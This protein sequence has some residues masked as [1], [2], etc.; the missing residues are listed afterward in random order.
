MAERRDF[1]GLEWV[2]AELDLTLASA[3]EALEAFVADRED[4]GRLRFC[5]T[6]L[7]QAYGTLRMLEF[8][9]AEQLALELD[10][11]AQALLAGRIPQTDD[12]LEALMAGLVQLPAYIQFARAEG[13]DEPSTLVPL[14]Q[15]LRALRGAQVSLE[16]AAFRPDMAG[17]SA[18]QG[19]RV[20]PDADFDA[21]LR[22]LRQIFQVALAAV[23]REQE[24]QQN[25][26]RLGKVMALVLQMVSGHPRETLWRA[27]QGLVEGLQHGSILLAPAVKS[28]LRQLDRE[29]KGM[30]EQGAA[31]LD[32][33]P[34]EEPLQP[35][36]YYI[37]LS[38]AET[39][40]IRELREQFALDRA[41]PPVAEDAPRP[42]LGATAAVAAA[43]CE[44][45]GQIQEVIDVHVRTRPGEIDDLRELLPAVARVAST[46]SMLGLPEPLEVVRAQ[47]DALEQL[48]QSG[49]PGDASSVPRLMEIAARLIGVESA[50]RVAGHDRQ[51][52]RSTEG[53]RQ[54]REARQAV[55]RQCRT[56]LEQAKECIVDFVASQWQ[57]SRLEPL[58]EL[59][60]V[61]RGALEMLP[62]PECAE[63]LIGCERYVR[64]QLLEGGVQPDW[65]ALDL[66]ADA[67]GGVD[68]FIERTEEG[69]SGRASQQMLALARESVAQLG[70]LE[71][72][73]PARA[74]V[75]GETV[76]LPEA[77]VAAAEAEPQEAVAEV[78]EGDGELVDDEILEV[79]DEEVQEVQE[80]IDAALPAWQADPGDAENLSTLRR[81]FHTLKG[82]G[83]LVGAVALGELSWSIENMLN[84][85]I[86]RSVAATAARI[87]MA[88]LARLAIPGLMD[89]FRAG[90]RG[91]PD[92]VQALIDRAQQLAS[93]AADALAPLAGG[94]QVPVQPE[95]QE[96]RDAQLMAIFAAEAVSYLQ[97]LD[98]YVAAAAF[99]ARPE[100][101]DSL[102][103]ALHTLKGS[104][105]MA[106]VTR[107]AEVVTPIERL[108]KEL[109]ANHLS[110]DAEV[111]S[112]LG[113]ASRLV[114]LGLAQLEEAE[115]PAIPGAVDFV[116]RVARAQSERLEMLAEHEPRESVQATQVRHLAD[117]LDAVFRAVPLLLQWREQ[118]P[119]GEACEELR[120]EFA[121]LQGELLQIRDH[122]GS[123][124]LAP[125]GVLSGALAAVYARLDER[126]LLPESGLQVLVDAHNT[127]SDLLDQMAA[128]QTLGP[129]GEHL[130]ALAALEPFPPTL[131][132]YPEDAGLAPVQAELPPEPELEIPAAASTELD[133]EL[134]AEAEAAASAQALERWAS[135]ALHPSGEHAP[136]EELELAPP[137]G[138]ALGDYPEDAGLALALA[139]LP[140]EPELEI[141]AASAQA[142]E[143]WAS[144]A[145]HPSGE[146]APLEELELAPP[147]GGALGDYPE[148]AGLA[149]ALAE[150]P[151]E[152][153]LE[154]PAAASTELD[155]ELELEAEALPVATAASELSL[156]ELPAE[157]VDP[158]TLEIFLEEARELLDAM[159]P[160]LHAW[161]RD[162]ALAGAGD[163]L[164]RLLHTF[165]GG[166]RLTG[167]LRLGDLAHDCESLLEHRG[168]ADAGFFPALQ[169][170]FD[171]LQQSV[172]AL[173]A[174]Q[175]MPVFAP[176]PAA[177][178]EAMAGAVELPAA[179]PEVELVEP[180][181]PPPAELP[182]EEV[183][184][185]TL[186][187]FL[188]EAREL[189]DAMEPL[190]HAWPRDPAL[191]GAGDELKRLLHTFKGGARLTGLLRLGDLAHDCESLLEHR[192]PG[193]AGFFPALQGY[194]DRL[195]QSVEAL[196]A[197]GPMPLPAAAGIEAEPA[198]LAEAAGFEAPL[199][200]IAELTAT[201]P[202]EAPA[203]SAAPEIEAPEDVQPLP[204]AVFEAEAPEPEAAEPEAPA[205]LP[206]I[207]FDLA[208]L[209]AAPVAIGEGL[210]EIE[211]D[212]EAFEGSAEA[213]AAPTPLPEFDLEDLEE[214]L[215]FSPRLSD[216]EAVE[217][218]PAEEALPGLTPEAGEP[219]P[220]L[221]ELEPEWLQEELPQPEAAAPA[222]PLLALPDIEDQIDPDTLEI[223]LEE[224]WE[225]LEGIGEELHAWR[226]E[227]EARSHPE[228][229]KRLLHT[230]KGGAR[231]AGLLRLGGLAHEVETLLEGSRAPGEAVLA[232]VAHCHE[233][234]T[235]GIEAVANPPQPAAPAEA[236]ALPPAAPA[237][238]P[239]PLPEFEPV[240][241]P[242]PEPVPAG[243]IIRFP[244]FNLR[245]D[246]AVLPSIPLPL[247]EMARALDK[248]GSQEAVK[249]SAQL[250]EEL[251]NLAGETSISRARVE[252]QVNEFRHSL[253]DMDTTIHR[254]QDKLRRLD[255][256]TEAQVLFR[257]E[258]LEQQGAESWDPLEF[259]R[260]TAL[261]QLSRS[262]MESASDIS[263]LRD[264][265]ADKSRDLETLL[266]QQARINTDLQEGLM[267]S[268]MVPFSRMV[269]RLRRIVRQVAAELGKEVE[270]DVLNAEG[271]M[272]R[273]VME[274]MVAPLEHMLR[275]AVDHGIELP[276]DRA[277]ANKP[278][279][280]RIYLNLQ[281]EGGDIVLTLLDDGRGIDRE[282]VRR[283][284][285]E[286]GMLE[287]DARLTDHEILQF[288][289]QPGFSTAAA[290]TQI[291]GRGVGMDVV[292][293][294]IKLLGGSLDVQSELGS[295]SRFI[296]RLP[297]TVSVNRALMVNVGQDT[298]AVP[299]NTIEGI[300]RV[301][302]F[303][304]EAY[305]QPDAPLFEYAGQSYRM[306]YL[307]ALMHTADKP[308][309]SQQLMPLPVLLVRG[310][311]QAVAVQVDRLLGSRE[312]VVKPLGPQFSQVTGLSG[313]TVLGDG[314][315]VVILDLAAMVRS[316]IS[317]KH[318]DL[319]L[320]REAEGGERERNLLVM[321]VDDSVTVRKVTSRFL[322]RQGMDVL[323]AKDGVD[324]MALLQEHLP[325]LM[326]LDIEMPRMDGFEVANRMRH[327]ERLQHIPIIMITSRSGEKHRQRAL[328]IGVNKYMGKP[329]QESELLQAIES[330]TQGGRAR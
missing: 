244:E 169:G 3:R 220:G 115:P 95:V 311:E 144:E 223:F 255:M 308:D 53:E 101:S 52:A 165:K 212:A 214:L 164:K 263:D 272:D 200:E 248:R 267:R 62:L 26:D 327:S 87:E 207:E 180:V 163:E 46:L 199:T 282:A 59:L 201:A 278:A 67:I 294:E 291:S 84:R 236:E 116:A 60:H 113:E 301:S 70:G 63:I 275:N 246:V 50:L 285:V 195:Q 167:L 252:E 304:L 328:S 284:A 241:E 258:K 69:I 277:R 326:L 300:V 55:L 42:D 17:A 279:T 109:R 152:P 114:K 261:Q 139:E 24:T 29:F 86:D 316:D 31:W 49:A 325:D 307:G 15:D 193:D 39:P 37:A 138:G 226:R 137:A 25:L 108:V 235:S 32:A 266:V 196:E 1:V 206:E 249:I 155:I 18:R 34:G 151:P 273:S 125:L 211:F 312:V 222:L 100:L 51:A 173:E 61:V 132:D 176:P 228:E 119:A 142:L 268:R 4:L 264:T 197:G 102:Q 58:P 89:D 242:E 262:L 133:I 313:A 292:H 28:L 303:E 158:D 7:H 12:V 324:A 240:P 243:S 157:E 186:E 97:V 121:R 13:R 118:S 162:P 124:S 159:E 319:V 192:G 106:E 94:E 98:D 77:P 254:L 8:R 107:I 9:T 5:I 253:E 274:R 245:Q 259:D 66:L 14:I 161:P 73:A 79:F 270:F 104:A 257:Q 80:T 225:L 171:R 314:S 135:E 131:G 232:Q 251:V 6:Y 65:T 126:Q 322:E 93:P 317:R 75:A 288:I 10:L 35:M 213:V 299:L 166:A 74:A 81:A 41:L 265:L 286:R 127:L 30:L 64:N 96:E 179:E 103:R 21:K 154:I 329:Y 150:L 2:A 271:E 156:P 22:K 178:P 237:P 91:V 210:P 260:Y 229:L 92:D 57:P 160:L 120:Q 36:L 205:L 90:R 175:P 309:L 227:P 181:A 72:A 183:D 269:P 11:A 170:Y 305:Y 330:L 40:H 111:V 184:P 296:I 33:A 177:A 56:V 293:S 297:Y 208:E 191:A 198:P 99:Q 302:P 136:L 250:L 82:S 231:V 147:A 234:L 141:P 230:F 209:P 289:V 310:G 16:A 216:I 219:E 110:A 68:Y 83:R 182:A 130:E 204:L 174:G 149:L 123:E 306:R 233:L 217:L 143:R 298:Y 71:A 194:F 239:E 215:E 44:E 221:D 48:V 256:E 318:R 321:V 153:E 168:P 54:L 45:L 287:E 283:K 320:G 189:L 290:V 172:E 148:D 187:I 315:V 145:L 20:Q 188:E 203:E 202:V 247:A 43:L 140:P 190:L 38:R 323:L 105:H 112:L 238:E 122:S 218:E 78:G 295:G 134:E 23:V 27:G 47:R 19:A 281:R 280:G 185:D 76:A 117:D 128:G 88:E 129:V 85:V 224:A 276:A 146:H